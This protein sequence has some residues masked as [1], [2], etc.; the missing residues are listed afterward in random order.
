MRI[1]LTL[2][3]CILISSFWVIS[4]CQK[5]ETT[6]TPVS[7]TV[8]ALSCGSATFSTTAASGMAYTGTAIVPYTGGT[9]LAYAAG[10]AVA[11]TGVTGLNATLQAGTLSS[12]AG[13]LTYVISGTPSGAGTATF[14]LSFGGQSCSL[15][16]TVSG[17][18]SGTASSGST[19]ITG[20]L[21]ATASANTTCATTTGLTRVVCLAE[22]FKAT[23]SSSQVAAMQFTYSKTNAQKWS[24]LPAALSARIGINLSTLSTTQLAA[25]RDLMVAVLALN[26]TDEGYDEMLGNLVADDYLNT[27]GG[28]SAYGAG[29]FYISFLGT[30][31]TT[32]LWEILFTGHHYTQPYTF[33]AG[34]LTGVTPA[35]RGVEPAAAV[36]A[37]SRSYQPFEQERQTF[38]T[39]LAGLSST[40]Q[41]TARLSGTFTDLVLGPGKDGQFPV[42]KVGIRVGT[43]SAAEQALVL[44]AIK[45]YVNDLDAAT[46]APILAK[47]TSELTDTYI[48]YSGTTAVASANDYVRI[49]GPGVWI[50]FSYQGGVI[51]K[52]APHPHSVWRDHASDYG[53]N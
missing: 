51:V 15:A 38:A 47:Y 46:A 43:L 6:V 52:T 22:A 53:G 20:M 39:M 1:S 4:S 13:N 37:N 42:T 21:A 32:G 49:D 33:N 48:A 24:N 8:S 14:A 35:F 25:F 7:A 34:V 44:N 31:S 5:N 50:E 11:S 45:L 9:G 41:T 10:S 28:G 36:S 12:G 26:T 40:E 23:L 30:P 2:L 17:T 27:I 3:A 16:L 19:T 29:N 18:N